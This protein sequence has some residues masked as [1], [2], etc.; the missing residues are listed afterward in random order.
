MSNAIHFDTT[1]GF[2]TRTACGKSTHV[3]ADAMR[4]NP[5]Q[6]TRDTNR[7]SCKSCRKVLDKQ[8]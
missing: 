3:Y 6:T 4:R 1:H 2:D 7:V 8:R 5:I